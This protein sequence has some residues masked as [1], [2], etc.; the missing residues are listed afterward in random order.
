[1]DPLPQAR[2]GHRHAGARG[3]ADREPAEPDGEQQEHEQA[4]PEG[5]Q[6]SEDV[7]DRADQPVGPAVAVL[8][9]DDA[10]RPAE[11]A[12]DD[13]GRGEQHE[14]VG[15]VLGDHLGDR[16][17]Q[18]ERGAQVSVQGVAPPQDETARRPTGRGPTWPSG[19]RTVSGRWRSRRPS[20]VDRVH[21]RG[22]GEEEGQ[23]AHREDQR[24]ALEDLLQRV[25][26]RSDETGAAA[27]GGSGGP[28]GDRAHAETPHEPRLW[29]TWRKWSWGCTRWVPMSRPS[30]TK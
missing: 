19:P 1:M 2:V 30:R 29:M 6:R 7:A 18:H 20:R 9:R 15:Q 12:R 13:P 24:G 21:R 8:A 16:A 14:R 22:L 27:G 3:Q 28:G 10:E 4:E 17:L 23:G 25:A 26:R 11:Q 5:R